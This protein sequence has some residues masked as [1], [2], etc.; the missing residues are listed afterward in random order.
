MGLSRRLDLDLILYVDPAAYYSMPYAD[1]PSVAKMI[2]AVNWKYRDMG[3]HMMLMVP[4]RVGT[5]S[6]ELGVPTAFSDISEFDIVCEIAEARAG[7]NP[8][9]SYG[10]HIFQ[11]LVEEQILYTAVFADEKTVHY[12]PDRLRSCENHVSSIP[13]GQ[14]LENIVWLVDVSS[15]GCVLYNDL[16]QEHLLLIM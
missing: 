16:E 8:D 4:G 9:L 11:D 2:G 15:S 6:P 7:Y 14:E 13:G 5:S 10:S 3:K 12:N 1:K